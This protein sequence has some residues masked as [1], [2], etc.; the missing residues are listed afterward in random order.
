MRTQLRVPLCVHALVALVRK[1]VKSEA[2]LFEI[3]Q[4]LSV[5][6]FDNP[7]VAT[8]FAEAMPH[9]KVDDL[10]KHLCL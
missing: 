4:V 3:L 10:Q 2:S 5:S 1:Q 9:N 6:V 8:L 7:P